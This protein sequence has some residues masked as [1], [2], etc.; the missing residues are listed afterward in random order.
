M[1]PATAQHGEYVLHEHMRDGTVPLSRS[2]DDQHLQEILREAQYYSIEGLEKKIKL[3][4]DS[5]D[6]VAAREKSGEKEYKIVHFGLENIEWL[7]NKVHER[8]SRGWELFSYSC[9][10]NSVV[11]C[12]VKHLSRSQTQLLDR[13]SKN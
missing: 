13:L 3:H 12:F 6:A 4:L 9:T 5:I 11:M 8:L 2:N 7:N 1:A 10:D